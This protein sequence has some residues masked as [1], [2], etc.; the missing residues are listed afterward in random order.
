LMWWCFI[1]LGFHQPWF[2][3]QDATFWIFRNIYDD[4]LMHT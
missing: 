4:M 1:H 2:C 3:V